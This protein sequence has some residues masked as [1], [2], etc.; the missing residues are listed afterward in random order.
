MGSGSAHGDPGDARRRR[1]RMAQDRGKKEAGAQGSAGYAKGRAITAGSDTAR[2]KPQA[3]RGFQ[4]HQPPST[5]TLR[6][7]VGGAAELRAADRRHLDAIQAALGGVGDLAVLQ[8][9]S[10]QV[11]AGVGVEGIAV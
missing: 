7:P 5:G 11:R 4:P 10:Q 9:Q 8:D 3:W 2:P 1:G 6:M